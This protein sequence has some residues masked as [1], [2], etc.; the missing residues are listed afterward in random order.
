MGPHNSVTYLPAGIGTGKTP[1]NQENLTGTKGYDKWLRA[2]KSVAT[3]VGMELM[4]FSKKDK[5]IRKQIAKDTVDTLNTQKI[6]G[7]I[8]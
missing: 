4:K 7:M 8:F 5:D 2:I 6:G 3:E 1:N